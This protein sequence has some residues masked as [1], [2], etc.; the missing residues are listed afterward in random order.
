MKNQFKIFGMCLSVNILPIAAA[1]VFQ[2]CLLQSLH[3]Q[4]MEYVVFSINGTNSDMSLGQVLNEGDQIDVPED[5]E[6]Q[7]LSKQGEIVSLKGPV[8]AVVTNDGEDVQGEKALTKISRLLFDDSKFV[9]TLGG[10][11]SFDSETNIEVNF[12]D[13]DLGDPWL[14]KLS[15]A[16]AYC[17]AWEHPALLRARIGENLTV[18]LRNSESDEKE[19]AWYAGSQTISLADHLDQN[20]DKYVIRFGTD[21]RSSMVFLMSNQNS[22]LAEQAAWMAAKGCRIQALKLL[23]KGITG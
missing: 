13:T 7:L 20:I 22:T 5:V 23:A 14:P 4:S 1:L 16:S 8:T 9:E 18:H 17:L 3:A 15:D 21:N 6:I 2:F 11:R 19:I 10:T 12:P